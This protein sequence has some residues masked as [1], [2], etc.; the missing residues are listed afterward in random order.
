MGFSLSPQVQRVN[1]HQR[2]ALSILGPLS[3]TGMYRK[4]IWGKLLLVSCSG[5]TPEGRFITGGGADKGFLPL[6]AAVLAPDANLQRA[7]SLPAAVY[8]VFL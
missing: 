3:G 7:V 4:T 6:S 8:I 1:A 5:M 2:T